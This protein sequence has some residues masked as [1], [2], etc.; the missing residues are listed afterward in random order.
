[1][2]ECVGPSAL[3][4]AQQHDMHPLVSYLWKQDGSDARTRSCEIRQ[5]IVDA[6]RERTIR[7]ST[8]AGVGGALA[9]LSTC[10]PNFDD[11]RTRV[12]NRLHVRQLP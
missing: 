5:A 4:G 12:F 10:L 9:R 6:E 3:R 7:T 1:M 11:L 2:A 8:N